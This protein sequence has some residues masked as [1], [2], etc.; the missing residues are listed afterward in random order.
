M[1]LHRRPPYAFLARTRIVLLYLLPTLHMVGRYSSVGIATRY[2]LGG[3]WI[4]SR[5]GATFSAPVQKGSE[6]HPASYTM[7][8]G[9]FPG[10]KWPGRGVDHRPHLAPRLKKEYSYTST[11]PMG[12]SGLL[13]GKLHLYLYLPCIWSRYCPP[14]KRKF[15]NFLPNYKASY[16]TRC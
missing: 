11:P 12:L 15:S 1:E 14:K 9:S 16:T 5:W 13:Q 10:V 3:P 4:E 8:T 2:K 6:A 7:G